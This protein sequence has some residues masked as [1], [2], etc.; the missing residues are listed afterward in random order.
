MC[1]CQLM[2]ADGCGVYGGYTDKKDNKIFLT[3]ILEGSGTK[4]YMTNDLSY[5]VKI[6]VPFLIY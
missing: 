1:L 4:S 3:Y 5:M 6:F 2:K